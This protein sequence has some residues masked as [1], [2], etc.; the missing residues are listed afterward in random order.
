MI[1]INHL[2]NDKTWLNC[3]VELD[4]RPEAIDHLLKHHLNFTVEESIKTSIIFNPDNEDLD[5][6]ND[7]K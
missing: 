1:W 7:A 3:E 4:S 2:A 6:T 5:K